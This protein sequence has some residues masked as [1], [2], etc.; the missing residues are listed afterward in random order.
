MSLKNK[1]LNM[2]C[3]EETWEQIT[4]DDY[5]NKKGGDKDECN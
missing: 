1:L 3:D 4:F 5:L 2:S